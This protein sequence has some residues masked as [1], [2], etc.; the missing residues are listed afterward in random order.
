M[1]QSILP[2]VN[3]LECVLKAQNLWTAEHPSA[4]ALMSQEP[5]A[6]DH[7]D[8][9]EW[10]QWLFIPRIRMMIEEQL[11]LPKGANISAMGDVFCQVNCVSTD[12]LLNCLNRIDEAMNRT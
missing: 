8:F 5:F 6:V 2:L 11:P 7:M 1:P 10:L 9:N 4:E 3:E 12:E